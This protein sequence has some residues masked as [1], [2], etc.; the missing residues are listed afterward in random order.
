MRITAGTLGLNGGGTNS[1]LLEVASGATLSLSTAPF[2]LTSSG[3]L[4]GAGQMSF[5]SLSSGSFVVEGVYDIGGGTSVSGATTFPPGVTLQNLGSLLNVS[6]GTLTLNSGEPVSLPALR[7]SGGALTGSD[8]ITTTGMLTWTG[9][10]LSGSGQTVAAGGLLINGSVTLDGRTLENGGAATW[11]G[12]HIALNN[13]AVLHNRVGAS[14]T[15]QNIGYNINASSG[16]LG[17]FINAGSLVKEGAS[18]N[19]IFA[20]VTNSGDVRITAGTLGLNGGYTQTGGSTVLNGGALSSNSA[21]RIQGGKLTGIGTVAAGVI[22]GGVVEPGNGVGSLTISGNYEQTGSGSLRV[23]I[24]GLTPETEFDRLTV[25]GAATLTGTLAISLT[26]GFTPTVGDSFIVM[27]FA[28]R[29]G[30]FTQVNGADLGN[31]MQ[32]VKNSESANV[33]L[34]VITTGATAAHIDADLSSLEFTTAI[35]PEPQIVVT[36]VAPSPATTA[37]YFSYL[38]IVTSGSTQTAESSGEE[39]AAREGNRSAQLLYLP[40]VT[41]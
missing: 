6:N 12:G 36:E 10:T 11:T 2:A 14:F 29:N 15:A 38:P 19:T 4:R 16:A 27:T 34:A 40:V 5:G 24:G 31:E 22:N 33:T 13:G 37:E 35:T 28:S 41:R 8:S 9:G 7:L 39:P 20:R 18:T 23:Q 30:D 25:T 26:N 32:F 3:T 1:G 17:H 21:L